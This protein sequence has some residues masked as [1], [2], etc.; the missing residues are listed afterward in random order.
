ML[1]ERAEVRTDQDELQRLHEQALK[2]L[3]GLDALGLYL[4]GAHLSL[5]IEI[6][7]QQHPGLS[8]AE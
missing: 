6:M 5:A 2:L 8:S 1:V 4:A 3:A 7:Q